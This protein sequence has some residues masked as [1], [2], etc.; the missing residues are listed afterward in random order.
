M[1]IFCAINTR[2]IPICITY[3]TPWRDLAGI[4]ARAEGARA[5]CM[6]TSPDPDNGV[7]YMIYSLWSR[8]YHNRQTS[9]AY[10]WPTVHV[11][12]TCTATQYS[13]VI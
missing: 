5:E 1:A 8:R 6:Y 11:S 3:N 13:G 9:S 12:D 7:F 10:I 4:H 2:A